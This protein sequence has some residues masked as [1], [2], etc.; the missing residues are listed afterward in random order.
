MSDTFL[1]V[2]T[3]LNTQSNSVEIEVYDTNDSNLKKDKHN[4]D[5]H[6]LKNSVE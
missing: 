5:I 3:K 2:D 4:F 6:E 1:K